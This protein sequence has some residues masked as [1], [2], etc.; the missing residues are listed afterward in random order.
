MRVSFKLAVGFGIVLALAVAVGIVGI[1]GMVNLRSSAIN[2]YENRVGSLKHANAAAFAFDRVLVE[3]QN[4]LIRSLHDDKQSAIESFYSFNVNAE[5]FVRY[6]NLSDELATTDELFEFHDRILGLFLNTYLPAAREIIERSVDDV[7]NHVNRLL[8]NVE[9]AQLSNVSTEI[10]SL[11]IGLVDLNSA[12]VEQTNI[13]NTW[14]IQIFISIQILLLI[15]AIFFAVAVALYVIRDIAVPIKEA[16]GVLN[17]VAKGNFDAQIKGNYKGDFEIIKNTVNDTAGKLFVYL[18]DKISAERQAYESDLEKARVEAATEAMFAGINYASKIQRSL[19]PDVSVLEKAF[20]DYSVIYEPRDIVGGDIYWAKNFDDGTILC[21]CDCTG[22]GTPGA[23]LTMLVVSAFESSVT[24]KNHSDVAQIMYD[25]DQ[26]LAAVLH[27]DSNTQTYSGASDI[28]DGCDLAIL[29]IAKNG[30]VAVA[31][32]HTS[33]FVCDG[34]EIMQYKGQKIFIGEGNLTSK[35]DVIVSRIAANPNNKFYIASDGLFDQ[36]GEKCGRSFGHSMFKQIIL[37]NHQQPQSIISGKIWNA[38]EEFRG[39]QS[40]RDDV[41]L[42]T[43]I[44]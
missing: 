41:E 11:M 10:E 27:L 35:D 7:P 19:L 37:E 14:M 44:K 17:E 32:G 20:T 15:I 16:V 43:F 36:I 38:F 30:D 2:M 9:T 1:L 12:M 40:Q 6:M 26:R 21:V 39:E 18:N 24:E 23:L 22:H 42:V 34:D 25:L 31:A 33:V 29:F 3:K 4:V 28:S 5:N 8:I 13:D